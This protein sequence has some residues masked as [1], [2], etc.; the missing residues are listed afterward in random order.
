MAL[1]MVVQTLCSADQR[2][3]LLAVDVLVDAIEHGRADAEG[4][5]PHVRSDLA[6]VKTSRLA[7]RL[8][9][10]AAAGPLQRTVVRDLLDST[11]DALAALPGRAHTPLLELFDELSAQSGVGVQ[12]EAARTFLATLT[13]SSK[14]AKAAKALLGR[15]GEPPDEE[16]RLALEARLR[17][18]E[19]WVG[20]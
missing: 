7:A 2:E 15:D 12:S 19:H 5:A 3:Y 18:A 14:A 4:L 6:L 10:L 1:R 16:A 13:G 11:V 20:A 8:T 17:R 9:A